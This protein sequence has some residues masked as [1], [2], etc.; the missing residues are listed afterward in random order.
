M[1]HFIYYSV[2]DDKIFIDRS[3]D[4]FVIDVFDSQG[5]KLYEIEKDYEK[6]KVTPDHK[7][8]IINRFK[9]DPNIKSA[10]QQVGGWEETQKLFTMN[11]PPIYPAIQELVIT[12]KKIYIQTFKLKENKSEYVVMDLKG[13]IIN[14]VY[15]PRFENTPMMSKILG[16][17]L[18]TIYNDKLYYLMENEDEEE[19]EL[20]MEEIK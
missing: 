20:H 10:S 2:C 3:P 6:L 8:E 15:L 13:N 19:W 9:E 17:K 12:G 16:A 1:S 11:F 18:H 4:G 5:N 7:K 14:R